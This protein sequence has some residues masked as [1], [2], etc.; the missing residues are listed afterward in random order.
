[1]KKITFVFI[2]AISIF[3]CGPSK[4]EAANHY[5]T[6][7]AKEDAIVIGDVAVTAGQ[8]PA[9]AIVF[10]TVYVPIVLDA[11]LTRPVKE[12]MTNPAVLVKVPAT[13]PPLNAGNGLVLL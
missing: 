9:A 10:V 5:E 6:I 1:M 8:P 2:I 13:P 7:I 11:R 4:Q 3:S 12:L